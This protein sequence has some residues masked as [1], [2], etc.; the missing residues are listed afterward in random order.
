MPDLGP[1]RAPCV[2][3]EAEYHPLPHVPQ[4]DPQQPAQ[5][6]KSVR[7]LEGTSS[8]LRTALRVKLYRVKLRMASKGA[9]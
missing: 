9:L 3:A 2:Y 5:K 7:G 6:A 1:T 8:F 4:S